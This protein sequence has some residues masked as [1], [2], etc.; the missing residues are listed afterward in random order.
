M[1]NKPN[2]KKEKTS[3][4]V[5]L[6]FEDEQRLTFQVK[7]KEF[8]KKSYVQQDF[9][10]RLHLTLTPSQSFFFQNKKVTFLPHNWGS[11]IHSKPVSLHPFFSFP[12]FN[13]F[14]FSLFCSLSFSD[15]T[16][17][18]IEHTEESFFPPTECLNKKYV[19][20][21]EK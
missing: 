10:R 12:L 20:R 11:R 17:T 6:L 3:F 15:C 21:V 18:L 13:F 8:L 2:K 5:E 16:C 9:N 19:A 1:R 4:T 14:L 7:E